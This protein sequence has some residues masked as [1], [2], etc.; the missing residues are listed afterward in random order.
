MDAETK[1]RKAK[2]QIAMDSPFFSSIL[3]RRKIEFTDCNTARTDG[4]KIEVSKDFIDTLDLDMTVFLLLHE[5]CHIAYKHHTR[6]NNRDVGIW[7]RAA[8]YV[9]NQ[10]MVDSGYKM[11]EGGL[12]DRRFKNM[13]AEQVYA[14]IYNEP[15]NNGIQFGDVVE[16][17]GDLKELEASINQEVAQARQIAKLQGKMPITLDREVDEILYQKKDWKELLAAFVTEQAKDDYS[18][19]RPN[20]RYDGDFILPSLHSQKMGNVILAV[21]TSGSINRDLLSIFVQELKDISSE[22]NVAMTVLYVDTK[23]QGIQ[24]FEPNDDI[25]LNIKGG[26]GTDFRPAFEYVDK[27]DI[28]GSC[29][30]YFTDGYCNS[31]PDSTDLPVFWAVYNNKNFVPPFGEVVLTDN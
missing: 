8:D 24:E 20:L 6:I 7:N 1:I 14:A 31:F 18:F 30:I 25:V 12:F 29:L 16:P 23:V 3:F 5:V 15:Q 27:E 4:T 21:D 11:I 17:Q 26:G 10:I 9:I 2:L 13:S 28:E 19:S 22:L